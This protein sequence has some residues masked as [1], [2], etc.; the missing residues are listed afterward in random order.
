M[1]VSCFWCCLSLLGANNGLKL[2]LNVEQYEY[3]RGPESD[4]GIKVNK[5]SPCICHVACGTL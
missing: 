2:I 4:A 1:S 5:Q 3:M